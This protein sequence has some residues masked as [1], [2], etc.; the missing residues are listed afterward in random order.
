MT[1]KLVAAYACRAGGT[2]LYGK[3]LQNLEPN[4]TILDHII[5]AT[6][7]AK[8]IDE[9]VLGISEGVENKIFI[10]IARRH[11]IGHII[12]GEQDVLKRL[13]DCGKSSNATDI[14][15][16]TTEC[17]FIA[18]EFLSTAWQQHV[19]EENDIT[20]I[21]YL[22]QG[23]NFEIYTQESLERFHLEGNDEERSEYC[24]A[25]PRRRP[26]LFKIGLIEPKESLKRTDLRLTVDYPEDLILCRDT[27]KALKEY[28]PQIPFDKIAQYVDSKPELRKLVAPFVSTIPIWASVLK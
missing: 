11:N 28:A 27:Y 12:G 17:P 6:K 15:R 4:Y 8:E 19:D 25:Y 13:I 7:A 5:E 3:P 2:R 18:W 26:D 23:V 10:D 1:R 22:P 24:S 14:F 20:V 9:I 21:D 16:I